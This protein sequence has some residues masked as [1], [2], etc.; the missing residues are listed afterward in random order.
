MTI[1][2]RTRMERKIMKQHV[3]KRM[4]RMALVLALALVCAFGFA[5]CKADKPSGDAGAKDKVTSEAPSKDSNNTADSSVKD[6]AATDE[7]A[8]GD[9][10]D[11]AGIPVKKPD[12]IEWL[13]SLKAKDLD[14]KDFDIPENKGKALTVY[15]VWATWCSPCVAELPELAKIA[16]DYESK[17]VRVIGVQI[18]AT[19]EEG[20][21]DAREVKAAKKIFADA[22]AEYTSI[23]PQGETS[24]ILSQT[25]AIPATFIVDP[26]GGLVDTVVG[27]MNY[28]EWSKTIDKALNK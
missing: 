23:I 19:N 10:V 6:D 17:G 18:D 16:K 15:N 3:G 22:K 2:E 8:A 13:M 25:D 7:N 14:G 12:N 5:A 24:S 28:D 21:S 26:D 11:S 9:T 27:S 1:E 20:D 4:K